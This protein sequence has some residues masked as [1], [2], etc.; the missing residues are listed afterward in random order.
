MSP[1]FDAWPSSEYPVSLVGAPSAMS[2]RS[3]SDSPFPPAPPLSRRATSFAGPKFLVG[4][5]LLAR[6]LFVVGKPH[7]SLTVGFSDVGSEGGG[8]LSDVDEENGDA[9]A[10]ANGTCEV[11]CEQSK[12]SR[13]QDGSSTLV[14]V[15]ILLTRVCEGRVGWT[16][17]DE[18]RREGKHP[19]GGKGNPSR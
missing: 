9:N 5:G 17:G 18:W 2:F 16:E 3:S 15:A 14:G 11:R 4:G 12:V 8:E 6:C 19:R 7:S 1:N 10:N 13:R